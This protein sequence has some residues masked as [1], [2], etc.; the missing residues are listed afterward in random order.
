V[1]RV[2]WDFPLRRM[3]VVSQVLHVVCGVL[4]CAGGPHCV[5]QLSWG[6]G[7]KHLYHDYVALKQVLSHNQHR[8][9]NT[10]GSD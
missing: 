10:S 2:L 3:G 5:S 8:F 4:V 9:A 6:L 1:K 7:I